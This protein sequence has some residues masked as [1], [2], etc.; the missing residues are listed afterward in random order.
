MLAP[1]QRTSPPRT[2]PGDLATQEYQQTHTPSDDSSIIELSFDYELDSAGNYVRISKGSSSNRSDHSSPPTPIDPSPLSLRTYGLEASPL[3]TVTTAKHDASPV[4]LNSPVVDRRGS[5]S[6][7]ESY[8][9][10]TAAEQRAPPATAV[11][12]SFGRVASGPALSSASA[13]SSL[14][15]GN[16]LVS[17]LRR[18]GAPRAP[19]LDHHREADGEARVDWV[20]D[21]NENVT[22]TE[23]GGEYGNNDQMRLNAT[24]VNGKRSS[25]VSPRLTGRSA[26]SAQADRITS[27]LPSRPSAVSSIPSSASTALARL[28]GVKA[29]VPTPR[30]TT[31]SSAGFDRINEMEG[32]GGDGD[33][34]TNSNNQWSRYAA[35]ETERSVFFISSHLVF[36]KENILH[37]LNQLRILRHP[38]DYQGIIVMGLYLQHPA[39][40]RQ[41]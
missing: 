26:S 32:G 23:S 4:V 35:E 19:P 38:M 9:V 36:T 22:D 7:S 28:R 5:L 29:S 15:A 40:V 13:A 33:V 11:A 34:H 30:M 41:A 2:P 14:R 16:S 24:N 17:G 37:Q 25:G 39:Q 8:P 20:G 31:G 10:M 27:A 3:S 18:V 1:M 6:R 21:E 12:R